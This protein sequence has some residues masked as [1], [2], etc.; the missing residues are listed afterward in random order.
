M[1]TKQLEI[2]M[3]EKL[4]EREQKRRDELERVIV[5]GIKAAVQAWCALH[6][7]RQKRYY[8]STHHTWE[9]YCDDVLGVCRQV[10]SQYAN[11]GEVL[12]IVSNCLQNDGLSED[13]ISTYLPQ[14]ESQIRPLVPFRKEP[15]KLTEIC[16]TSFKTAPEGK[17]TAKHIQQTIFDIVG[18][19]T[20]D[21][22]GKVRSAVNKDELL[23]E[24]FKAAFERFLKEIELAKIGKYKKTSREAILRHL[25]TLRETIANDG[26]EI[27]DHT[28]QSTSDRKKLLEGGFRIFR[29]N[30]EKLCIE[31]QT[32]AGF[33]E[34]FN[35]YPD[36]EALSLEFN[37]L[38]RNLAHLRG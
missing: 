34:H 1:A 14:N 38:M 19:K 6:E 32:G 25:D 9:E 35:S 27:A 24:E 4:P 33:W 16:V 5:Y 29:K 22:T 13:E 31:E 30:P 26:E 12:G 17:N 28:I 18:K 3:L 11:A 36:A 20:T 7:I 8:R 21:G 15:E 23:T 2:D 37:S 10:G